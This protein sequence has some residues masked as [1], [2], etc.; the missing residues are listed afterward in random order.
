MKHFIAIAV[1]LMLAVPASAAELGDDGLYKAAW[2]R[3]TFKDL[4][5]DFAEADSEGK[6]LLL[7]IEQRGCLYCAE[8]HEVTFEDPRIKAMLEDV[9][10]PV[11]INLGGDTEV[12]DTDGEALTEK[13]AM[14]KWG[15]MFTPTMIFLPSELDP[16]QSAGQQAVAIMPGAFAAGTTLD[17]LTWVAQER[18]LDQSEEDFQR[19]H[20]RMIRERDD[21]DTR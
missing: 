3:D 15:V 9:Y 2:L 19:Y 13:S 14:R 11:Q 12:I 4:Q 17:L 10:F 5:D 1:A 21:G 7:L 16:T 18:Y 8:M 20:A 6:R